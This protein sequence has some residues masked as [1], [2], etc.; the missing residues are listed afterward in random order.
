M[1]TDPWFYLVAIPAVVLSGLGKG[2]LSGLGNVSVPLMA[3]IISPVQAAAVMLPILII[4][5]W[6]GVWSYRREW[7]A[8][9]VR[10]VIPAAMVGVALGWASASWVSEAQIRLVVGLIGTVF[11]LNHWLGWRP[12]GGAPGPD[13]VKG[14][15]WGAVMGFTSF[16]SH[17]GG[18]PFAVYLLPQRL[19]S[20][21]YAGTSVVC[22]AAVNHAKIVPYWMLGQF[23]LENV[24]TSAVLLPIAWTSAIAGVWI[25][26]HM[27]T[28][29]FYTFAY[30]SLLVVSLKLVW[31]GALGVF[32]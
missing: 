12:K 30:G 8:A 20:T 24:A 14:S 11:T 31:D 29:W 23:S 32:G 9:N 26:R 15:F 1:I 13:V 22:F 17:G 2:G 5:D 3:L 4:G 25:V 10:I 7:D 19:P 16:F 6:I 28:G 21:V 18:P 27:E